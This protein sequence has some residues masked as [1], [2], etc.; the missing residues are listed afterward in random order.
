[1]TGKRY[2]EEAKIQIVDYYLELGSFGMVEKV[3]GI[4][5]TTVRA[6]LLGMGVVEKSTKVTSP[7]RTNKYEEKWNQLSEAEKGYVCGLWAT[8]GC[9]QK[10]KKKILLI[11]FAEHDKE[12][13]YNLATMLTNPPC[14]VQV[15][16]GGIAHFKGGR[17]SQRQDRYTI[18]FTAHEMY[19]Y[20]VSMG[21]TPAKTYTLN[22]KLDDKSDEFLL[23]FVRGVIDGDGSVTVNKNNRLFGSHIKISSASRVFL[24]K[25]QVLLGGAIY[26]CTR[27]VNTKTQLYSLEFTGEEARQIANLLPIEKYM[28]SRK[29]E[30]IIKYRSLEVLRKSKG[31]AR[32]EGLLVTRLKGKL[33]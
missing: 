4:P 7:K 2:S 11:S 21:I 12:V 28:M 23:N 20:M 22:P 33:T 16:A 6:I 29:T 24:E 14:H 31:T 9:L 8:D 19:D 17:D 3:Y 10:D 1:M 25:L 27:T 32:P 26:N 5:H 18:A 15:A 13:V 30:K